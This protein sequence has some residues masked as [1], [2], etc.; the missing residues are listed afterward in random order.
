MILKKSRLKEIREY[1][2][3]QNLGGLVIFWNPGEV[4]NLNRRQRESSKRQ[5]NRN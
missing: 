2:Q 5:Q 1:G 3:R 4:K